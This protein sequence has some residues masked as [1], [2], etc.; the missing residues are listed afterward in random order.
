MINYPMT[1]LTLDDNKYVLAETEEAVCNLWPSN[2]TDT[3]R[4]AHLI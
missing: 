2:I 1:G 3:S 4:D